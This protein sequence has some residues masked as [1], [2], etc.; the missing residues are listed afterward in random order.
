MEHKNMTTL[1]GRSY[2][3]AFIF[4]TIH[5]EELKRHH[6]DRSAKRLNG[7]SS[8]MLKVT[9]SDGII[10]PLVVSMQTQGNCCTLLQ[11]GNVGWCTGIVF[12]VKLK[13]PGF[14]DRLD[15]LDEELAC[16]IHG[17]DLENLVH[18]FDSSIAQLLANHPRFALV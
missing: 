3:Y 14:L 4:L 8:R 12:T 5:C 13:K 9:F 18:A 1:H 17:Q 10:S 2:I 15:N 6:N 16:L 7:F 11:D